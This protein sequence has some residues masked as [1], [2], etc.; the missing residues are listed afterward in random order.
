MKNENLIQNVV[1]ICHENQNR[2][3]SKWHTCSNKAKWMNDSEFS[4]HKEIK[5]MRRRRRRRGSDRDKVSTLKL[6]SCHQYILVLTG[7]SCDRWEHANTHRERERERHIG[8]NYSTLDSK[9]HT[10]IIWT[11]S[12]SRND[13][14]T[15]EWWIK[16]VSVNN[17]SERVRVC[18][19]VNIL[20]LVQLT[21][22]V[23]DDTIS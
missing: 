21:P 11:I 14:E 20:W 5:A 23:C 2:L 4:E 12:I 7:F 1:Y 18:Q 6:E 22:N 9:L 8:S 10:N 13:D 3:N 19:C 17:F 15:N 16:P